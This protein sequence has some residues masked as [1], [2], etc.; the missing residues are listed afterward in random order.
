[1]TPQEPSWPSGGG[2]GAGCA[3][4]LCGLL[5]QWCAAGGKRNQ[6][7]CT[8]LPFVA[9]NKQVCK[10]SHLEAIA[11]HELYGARIPPS[12][13]ALRPQAALRDAPDGPHSP[14]RRPLYYFLDHKLFTTAFSCSTQLSS[15][16][17]VHGVL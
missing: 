3:G 8:K 16:S 13:C 9:W 10:Y 5:D 11:H 4:V 1:M 7:K 17:A 2:E 12:S 6:V 15:S 14:L